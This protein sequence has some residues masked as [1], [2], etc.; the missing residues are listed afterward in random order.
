MWFYGVRGGLVL[1]EGEQF[2]SAS[3]HWSKTKDILLVS[4]LY[5]AAL[6]SLS[7]QLAAPQGC[8]EM[9][10]S[11]DRDQIKRLCC[12]SAVCYWRTLHLFAVV[13]RHG[14]DVPTPGPN[15]GSAK[16]K[17]KVGEECSRHLVNG[18]LILYSFF[19]WFPGVWN[20]GADVSEHCFIFIVG[21]SRKNNQNLSHP[22]YSFCLHRLWRQNRQCVPK[23][24]HIKFRCWGIT[25]K[26]EYDIQNEAKFEI[27]RKC[28]I[29]QYKPTKC[30]FSKFVL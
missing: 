29:I 28:V 12:R 30:T 26:K 3:L 2:P 6:W 14:R 10:I 16:I 27:K 13:Y 24:R 15:V 7:L 11:A 20:L 25:Q 8:N 18:K 22:G 21:V 4:V 5:G 1:Y 23:R 17:E 9:K 19:G